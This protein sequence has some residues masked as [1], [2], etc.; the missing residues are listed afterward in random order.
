MLTISL[1][2][3]KQ[4]HTSSCSLA[5]QSNWSITAPSS[6]ATY[7]FGKPYRNQKPLIF[8]QAAASSFPLVFC[9]LDDFFST[10]LRGN[11]NLHWCCIRD[12]CRH[13]L[14]CLSHQQKNFKV[15]P[16]SAHGWANAVLN[17]NLPYQLTDCPELLWDCANVLF[18]EKEQLSAPVIYRYCVFSAAE[19][20]AKANTKWKVLKEIVEHILTCAKLRWYVGELESGST[21]HLSYVVADWDK[22]C[23]I[24]QMCPSGF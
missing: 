4:K 21:A 2:F 18:Q 9:I 22:Q 16:H 23:F 8:L 24:L 14:F 6:L 13:Y 5:N 20:L 12:C 17:I 7:H 11:T 3:W 15:Q 1:F 10:L 19:A